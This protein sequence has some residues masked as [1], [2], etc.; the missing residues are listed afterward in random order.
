MPLP[1]PTTVEPRTCTL[2]EVL[3]QIRSRLVRKVRLPPEQ[4]LGLNPEEVDVPSPQADHLLYFWADR[5]G[6][7]SRSF[8]GAGRYDTRYLVILGVEV[9]T[10]LATDPR[11]NLV[12]WLM[13]RQ[14]GHIRY[15]HGV[16]DALAG[17]PI[18]DAQGNMLTMPI[19]PQGAN[20]GRVAKRTAGWGRSRLGFEFEYRLKLDTQVG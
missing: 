9:V 10:R 15:A 8:D 7:S 6:M 1:M 20:S 14:Y 13:S 3:E 11:P 17:I 2:D 4:V 16:I 12:D 5:Q 18:E 19:V